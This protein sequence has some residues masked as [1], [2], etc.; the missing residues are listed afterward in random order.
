MNRDKQ[1]GVALALALLLLLILSVIAVSL[2]FLSQTETWASMNY[3]LICQARDAAESG[4]NAAANYL[5]YSYTPP[6]TAGAD[7]LSGYNNNTSPVQYPAGNTRLHDVVLATSNSHQSSNYP[8]SS[9]VSAFSAAAQGTL[10][11]GSTTLNYS[12]YA[13]LLSQRQVLPY[14]TTTYQTVQTWQITSD[15]TTNGVRSALEEVSAILEKQ[16]TPVFVYA[17]FATA[18]GCG[19]LNFGGGGG[20]ASYDSANLTLSG[21]VPVLVNGG[22]NVGTNGNLA[23]NGNPT[24]INGSLFTPRTGVGTC[25]SGNV[26]AWTNS[27]GHVTG[28]LIELPQQVVYPN[29]QPPTPAPPTTSQTLNNSAGDCAGVAGCTYG[30][31]P[32]PG[33]NGCPSGDFCLAPGSCPPTAGGNGLVGNLTIKGTVHLSGGCYN[34]NS[35][36][37]NAHGQLT[38]DTGPVVVNIAG[39]GQSTPLD[40]TGNGLIN[41]VGFNASMLQIL[42]AG[43]GAINIKGGAN[44]VG[45]LYAPNATL[46]FNSAGGNWYGAVITGS[47]SDLGHAQI[48]YDMNLQRQDV[49]VSA[50]MLD[51]FTWKKN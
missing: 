31:G 6:A 8:L 29:P 3:K 36:T 35:L 20:T 11:A 28:G 33:G 14:G 49:T 27:S 1:K 37:E 12:S 30:T 41:N 13:K 51:S 26:T 16:V 15:G 46:S 19:A 47:M 4:I 9:A 22:G 40:L 24:T 42:Y 21:G 10:T 45:V 17:A 32:A 25:T 23:E 50:W 39:A 38:I 5:M 2:M 43:T 18:N 34:V 48:D 44:A 7:P